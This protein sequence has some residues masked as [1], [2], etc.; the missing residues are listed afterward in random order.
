MIATA[1]AAAKSIVGV[2]DP[3]GGAQTENPC[4]SDP[5]AG[6]RNSCSEGSGSGFQIPFCKNWK[7][8]GR[9]KLVRNQ[10]SK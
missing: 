6:R 9:R 3:H 4:C 10:R 8:N 7:K 1:T 2:F 5:F